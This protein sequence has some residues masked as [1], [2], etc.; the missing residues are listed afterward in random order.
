M[1]VAIVTVQTPFVESDRDRY[2]LEL[3]RRIEGRGHAVQAIRIPFKPYPP[4]SALEQMLAFKLLRMDSG[5]PD[6]VLAIGFPA[7]LCPIPRKRVW[8]LDFDAAACPVSAIAASLRSAEKVFAGSAGIADR[9]RTL[10]GFEAGE[11][12]EPP[13]D[14]NWDAILNQLLS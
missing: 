14:E 9:L 3:A 6:L 1:K 8:M 12:L 10:H 11:V 4:Q 7:C 2:A 13:T 5:D